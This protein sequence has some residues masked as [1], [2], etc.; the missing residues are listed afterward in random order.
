MR[1]LWD[2]TKSKWANKS[3]SLRQKCLLH[4]DVCFCDEATEFNSKET[5]PDMIYFFVLFGSNFCCNSKCRVCNRLV[6][7]STGFGATKQSSFSQKFFKS[8]G[9]QGSMTE[10]PKIL[11]AFFAIVVMLSG[12]FGR[13]SSRT[14]PT[15]VW[16]SY[17]NSFVHNILGRKTIC[18]F[19]KNSENTKHLSRHHTQLLLD[20]LKHSSQIILHSHQNII[21]SYEYNSLITLPSGVLDAFRPNVSCIPYLTKANCERNPNI[22]FYLFWFKLHEAFSL[23]LQ[24]H[25]ISFSFGPIC[26]MGNVTFLETDFIFCGQY[27]GFWLYPDVSS[28]GIH[29]AA[30]MCTVFR[31][32]ISFIIVDKK[33]TI[34]LKESFLNS[35]N[36][37]PYSVIKGENNKIVSSYH[38]KGKKL[39][40]LAIKLKITSE[41][42]IFVYDGPDTSSRLLK[43]RSIFLLSSFQCILQIVN[44]VIHNDSL[45]FFMSNETNPNLV[46][47]LDKSNKG[48]ISI[49]DATCSQS[50]C[51]ILINARNH[52]N[53]TILSMFYEGKQSQTCRYGG[54]LSVDL[55]NNSYWES[56]T[57]CK[58]DERDISAIMTSR[59]FY[60]F[61]DS[62]IVLLYWYRYLSK[63]QARLQISE[64]K[65][66]FMH[67]CP[68]TYRFLMLLQRG[69]QYIS[70][71][72]NNEKVLSKQIDLL[73]GSGSF[74]CV[75]VQLQ[76][77]DNFA[78]LDHKNKFQGRKRQIVQ[79]DPSMCLSRLRAKDVPGPEITTNITARGVL[80]PLP[81]YSYLSHRPQCRCSCSTCM[82]GCSFMLYKCEHC[83][84]QKSISYV[85]PT[86]KQQ[87]F[88]SFYLHT[89]I[90]GKIHMHNWGWKNFF[91]VQFKLNTNCWADFVFTT[92]IQKRVLY[93][94]LEDI[95]VSQKLEISKVCF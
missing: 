52:L 58:K 38:I 73:V 53:I 11:L 84:K 81:L 56:N 57:L 35:S 33:Q 16:Q 45:I 54:L 17:V 61:G 76:Q 59:S 66:K 47:Q 22:D 29:I 86:L 10:K 87:F 44:D 24:V 80:D 83:K 7:C 72:R 79:N 18:S 74:E 13:H 93:S 88:R 48:N 27:F 69:N 3:S 34:T 95:Y 21:H 89:R 25:S 30:Y 42:N 90:K 41:E 1:C 78:T 75:V 46:V 40:Y 92:E 12:A 64:T 36:D 32:N 91:I 85:V 82:C 43:N 15:N 23:I 70:N 14:K 5:N 77:D 62:L 94:E 68:C 71:L 51:S 67:F 9:K 20:L 37:K 65:C 31:V 50:P 8:I 26:R 6:F 2:E 28:F 49:P 63:V 39:F 55:S 60:S 4:C 19:N